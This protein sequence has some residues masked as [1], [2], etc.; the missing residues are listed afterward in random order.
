MVSPKSTVHRIYSSHEYLTHSGTRFAAPRDSCDHEPVRLDPDQT[1]RQRA[2]SARAAPSRRTLRER[3]LQESSCISSRPAA[4]SSD[5]R[6]HF[7]VRV[8]SGPK[9]AGF[10]GDPSAVTERLLF[11]ARLRSSPSGPMG[12]NDA[13]REAGVA[14]ARTNVSVRTVSDGFARSD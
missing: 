6:F 12:A 4:A 11:P 2:G 5:Y 7:L 9:H 13:C 10:I 8:S 3:A 14:G 1:R